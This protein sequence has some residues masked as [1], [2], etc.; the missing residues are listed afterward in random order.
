MYDK[1]KHSFFAFHRTWSPCF[2][3]STDC[4]SFF[5]KVRVEKVLQE[6][7]KQTDLRFFYDEKLLNSLQPVS[8]QMD[9]G[10]IQQA[11]SKVFKGQNLTYQIL[12]NTI[13]I[14]EKQRTDIE[15]TGIVRSTESALAGVTVSV[16][17]HTT[18]STKTDAN[19][20]FKLRVPENAVLVFQ[21]MGYTTERVQIGSQRTVNVTLKQAT[22]SWMR[23]LLSATV[24]S[25]K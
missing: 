21:Y 13:V 14:S 20:Q 22:H 6:I 5:K 7:S 16:E 25:E 9:H 18:L 12:N 24:R 17:G 4:Q 3:N 10:P 15:I 2:G 1:V 19:G 23:W 11:L 8:I